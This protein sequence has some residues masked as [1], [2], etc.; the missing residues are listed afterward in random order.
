MPFVT[1]PKRPSTELSPPN[2]VTLRAVVE[3]GRRF[4]ELAERFEEVDNF[5][6]GD[7]AGRI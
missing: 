5:L 2:R 1:E 4:V 7:G 3:G 6:V